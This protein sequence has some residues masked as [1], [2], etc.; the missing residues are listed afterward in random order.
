MAAFCRPT[1]LKDML[2]HS[3]TPPQNIKPGFS[4]CN[5]Y[6]CK[7]CPNTTDNHPPTVKHIESTRA[8]PVTLTTSSTS[9]HAINATTY[10][11][12]HKPQILTSVMIETPK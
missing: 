9:S 3:T 10:T 11:A 4:P 12:I 8:S 2:V 6:L 5:N 1:N 7:T